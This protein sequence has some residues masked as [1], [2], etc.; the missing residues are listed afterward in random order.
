MSS[1][2]ASRLARMT[3]RNPSQSHRSATPLELLF[4]LAFVL[5]IGQASGSFAHLLAE[6]HIASA[7]A[8]FTFAMFSICWAWINFTWFASAYDTDDWFYRLMTLVQMIG[9]IV[10]AL[11]VPALFE[12][13]DHGEDVDNRV[14]VIGYV[15]MRIALVVQWLRA[16]RQ[17]PARRA[18]AFAYV[19]FV[20]TAQLGWLL[21][22]FAP[23]EFWPTL[24]IAVVLF[25]VEMIGPVL[26]ERK[27]SGTPWHPHHM[28]ERYGLLTIIALGEGIFGTVAS[29][30]A[31]VQEHGWSLEAILVIVAGV[32]LTF[33]LWW[34]YFIIDMGTVLARFRS[35]WWGFSY[36][37]MLIFM[38]VAATG[39]GLHV[40]GYVIE[41]HSELGTLGAVIS[42]AIPVLVFSGVVFGLYVFLTRFIDPFHFLLIVG[43]IVVTG[44]AVGLAMLG[45]SI[46]WSL[47]VLML[48]PAVVVV[49]YETVG[50]RHAAQREE[51]ARA[52]PEQTQ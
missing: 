15:V 47:I 2:I 29:V 10:V 26:A 39:A 44:F 14:L 46:G 7:L 4:D 31:S 5:A 50:W 25:G 41:G 28:A 51:A 45:A 37:H 43:A 19:K 49:G 36:G 27:G 23:L 9:V 38:S 32:G 20:A 52:A 34:T 24:A 18:T 48:A 8:G 40:A 12:S 3:G 22:A 35:R 1:P 30:S 16:A 33:G 42:A 13:I 6:G 17:D 11:G 21:V